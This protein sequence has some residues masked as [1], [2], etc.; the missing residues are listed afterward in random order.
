MR[1]A[2]QT[3]AFSSNIRLCGMVWAVQIFSSP[4]YADGA[5]ISVERAEGVLG[6]RTGIFTLV[7]VFLTGSRIGT[8]SVLFS[9]APYSDPYAL[10]V[11]LRLSVAISSWR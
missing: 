6:S 3:R 2:Y 10:I 11:G 7:A 9:V 5:N 1:A 8:K 4:Q